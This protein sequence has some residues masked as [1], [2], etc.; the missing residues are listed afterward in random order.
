MLVICQPVI[1]HLQEKCDA[2]PQF[3]FPHSNNT[4]EFG[5]TNCIKSEQTLWECR[6]S[7]LYQALNR[8]EFAPQT[9]A[10]IR[11]L[12]LTTSTGEE[13]SRIFAVD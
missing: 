2:D 13:G 4:G 6:F 3:C 5:S 9:T 1:L 11:Y 12:P 10:L 7:L 8:I